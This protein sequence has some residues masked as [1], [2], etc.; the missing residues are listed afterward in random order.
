MKI[1]MI[2]APEQYRDEELIGTK[3]ELSLESIGVDIAS[4][5]KGEI[6]GVKG[7][8][9]QA[10]I[11]VEEIDAKTY[12][13]VVLIGGSGALV[14]R[15]D[16]LVREKVESFWNDGKVVAAICIAPTILSAMGIFGGKKMTV[17][18]S[19][20]EDL[21]YDGVVYVDEDVVV[22]GKLVTA[23][24]PASAKGFGK[25]VAEVLKNN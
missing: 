3:E 2:V 11:T 8:R 7:G 20:R 15:N 1:V 13:G 4:K 19:G 24:G 23:N 17:H 5:I 25:K 9:A 16:D 21:E 14:Y 10:N 18:K 12:D 22:D 6:V